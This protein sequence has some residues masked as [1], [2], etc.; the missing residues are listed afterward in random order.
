MKGCCL[1]FLFL[2]SG[3]VSDLLSWTLVWRMVEVLQVQVV[4]LLVTWH[5]GYY[6]EQLLRCFSLRLSR[7]E[8]G[9]LFVL[10]GDDLHD[11][12]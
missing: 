11:V 5:D 7:H 1:V 8:V 10:S 9:I 4:V 6:C 12:V 3:A 2:D